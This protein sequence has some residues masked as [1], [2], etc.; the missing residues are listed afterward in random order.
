M[1][2][3]FAYRIFQAVTRGSPDNHSMFS[4]DEQD[5]GYFR[6][7]LGLAVLVSGLFVT[8]LILGDFPANT[9]SPDAGGYISVTEYFKGDDV[10]LSKSRISR[11]I[12]PILALPLSYMLD[13]PVSFII[14]NAILFVLLVATFYVLSKNLLGESQ[15]AFYSALLLIFAYPVYYRGINVTVDLA[16]WL[17]F[18]STACFVLHFKKKDALTV[19]VSSLMAIAC[20]VGTLVTELVLA[21]FLLIFVHHF[22]DNFRKQ[23]A[24]SLIKDLFTIGVC[25]SIPVILFQL[26]IAS[27]FDYSILDNAQAKMGWVADNPLSLGPVGLL[28]SFMGAFIVSL[29]FLPFG[30]LEFR[31]HHRLATFHLAMLISTLITLLAIYVATIRFSFVLFPLIFTF[32]IRGIA[33]L[34]S[35]L[36]AA[37]SM[38]EHQV[39]LAQGTL[40]AAV[41]A[42]N[43]VLYAGFLHYGSTMEMA[44]QFLSFLL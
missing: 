26:A 31:K 8:F 1:Q 6:L 43:I 14:I 4:L 39:R 21:S 25:F 7:A 35:K 2:E 19:R 17:V 37:V 30:V 11:P 5:R 24:K 16:S 40:V 38:N 42:F 27:S 28:R 10:T 32:N 3:L 13:T 36:K 12:V 41:C 18:V 20:A 23:S 44:T 15:G 34:V 33:F 22:F 29:F 9:I